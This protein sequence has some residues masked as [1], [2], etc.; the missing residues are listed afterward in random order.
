[1]IDGKRVVVVVPAGRRRYME[2]QLKHVLRDRGIID[3][4][5]IW[6]NT[7]DQGDVAYFRGLRDTYPGWVTLDER[8]MNQPDVGKNENIHRFFMAC[9]DR[10]TVYVRLDD[11]I[12]YIHPGAIETLVRKR[13]ANPQCFLVYGNIVNNAVMTHL[14]QRI[15][16]M[17]IVGKPVM[18]NAKDDIGW[19]NPIFARAVH[20]N[21]L[22]R[23]AEGTLSA[24]FMNDWFLWDAAR[25]S[26]NC[27]S[28]LGETFL[29]R[30]IIVPDAEEVWLACAAPKATGQFNLIAGDALLCHYAFWTQRPELD[31]D[32]RILKAYA[33]LADRT[34]P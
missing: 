23:A 17:P 16:A 1:M 14:H 33:D 19:K 22:Q 12:V 27:I 25:V 32:R 2:V 26:I 3:E 29:E 9:R 13:L 34:C 5:R 10:D 6:V 21:F 15:R 11:D 28:W 4:Y 7:P 24:Y 31:R 18:Y 8:F 30:D 20:E